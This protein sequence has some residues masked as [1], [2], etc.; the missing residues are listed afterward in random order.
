ML[1]NILIVKLEENT[2]EMLFVVSL[3]NISI[4]LDHDK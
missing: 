2:F 1:E 4:E 3:T